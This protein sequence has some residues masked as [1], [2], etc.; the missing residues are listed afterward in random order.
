V[1][2]FTN[3][4]HEFRTPLTLILGP[5]E[6]LMEKK[7][8]LPGSNNLSLIHKNASRLLQL[9]DQLIDFRKM[10][11][12]KMKLR[13][14]EIDLIGFTS[15]ILES[16]KLI[17][18]RK[19]IDLKLVTKE[20]FLPVWVDPTIFDKVIFNVLS[21]A[22]KF[23]ESNGSITV[24]ISRCV[25]DNLAIVKV[26][27]SGR[28]MTRDEQDRIFDLY[29]QGNTT[30]ARSSS[31]IGLAVTKSFLDLHHGKIEVNSIPGEGSTFTIS[32]RIGND[33]YEK[34]QIYGIVSSSIKDLT[35]PG[36]VHMAEL[37]EIYPDK[38]FTDDFQ[39]S[40][41][42]SI[43]IIEDNDDLRA[44]VKSKLTDSYEVY[45]AG[46]GESAKQQV[47]NH[48]PDLIIC[49]IM[50]PDQDGLSLTGL[51]KS[52]PRTSHIPVVLLT[53]Q[54]NNDQKIAAMKLKADAYLTKPFNIH[55]LHE[56]I[57][58]L[59]SNRKRTR[60]HLITDLAGNTKTTGVK[61][62]DKKF[63]NEFT[64]YVEAN[65][66]NPDLS[67]EEICL[68]LGISKV[69]LY[70]K[71]REGLDISINEYILNTR[72]NKAKYLLQDETLTISEISYQVGFSSA[73]YFSTVFKGRFNMSPKEFRG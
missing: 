9:V 43:V 50:L 32:L 40:H 10:E 5:V 51:F 73:S 34:D 39:V 57:S 14:S 2:F 61:K 63:L 46:D 12:N 45:E 42:R 49:D 15:E 31:G 33:H 30:Y 23:T 16:Y 21:N 24:H 62:G 7:K 8:I 66:G 53:A 60:E 38:P 28:G 36:I 65:I 48:L 18:D 37:K 20:R 11:S 41:E 71:I 55:Y 4:S 29:Y 70:R 19:H 68:N 35:E 26:E 47:F 13:V 56:T 22:M 58:S 3:I 52:D 54:T 59:L 44:F 64:T 25:N 1:N 27:D 6:D 72:L 69:Q 17:A 67:V